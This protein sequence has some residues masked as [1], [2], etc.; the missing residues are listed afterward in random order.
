MKFYRLH[1]QNEDGSHGFEWF[2][3]RRKAEVAKREW[4]EGGVDT[5]NC[6]ELELVEV[7]PTKAGILQA[8]KSYA[9]HA[10]NG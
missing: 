8:L 2:T 6:A 5:Y 3:V 1:K 10:D 4:D 9:D 7:R